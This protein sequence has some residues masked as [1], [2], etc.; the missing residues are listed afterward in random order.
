LHAQLATAVRTRIREGQLPAGS[1]L[2]GEKELAAALGVSRHTVRHAL[3]ALVNEG[4]LHRQ[5]GARTVVASNRGGETVI[6][7]QLGRFYAFA[8]EVEAR[9]AHHRSRVLSREVLPADARLS[10]LLMVD[11]G[12]QVERIERLRSAND[13]ALT[14]ESSILPAALSTTFGDTDLEQQSIYDLLEQRHKISVVRAHESL[15]P[16][17]LDR[18]AA[19]LLD[20]PPVSPAF[21]VERTSWSEDG[22]VEW[23]QSLIRGDRYLYS[24]DLSR[25]L[26]PR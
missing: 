22:P 20:V 26:R 21:L 15:R 2:P 17:V 14:L 8:W 19:R 1:P 18:R 23:Q 12:T 24:V 9:G 10:Q 16:V 5:R 13:E 7:R 3:G 6:E 11:L 4:W 25:S